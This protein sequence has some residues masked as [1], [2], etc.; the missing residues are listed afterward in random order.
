M[1][2]VA[3]GYQKDSQLAVLACKF[4]LHGVYKVDL[5]ENSFK[6]L[7]EEGVKT[8]CDSKIAQ[9]KISGLYASFESCR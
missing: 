8:H 5:V 2:L 6:P 9:N 1:P 3:A 7:L 4:Y